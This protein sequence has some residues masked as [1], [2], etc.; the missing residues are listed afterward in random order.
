MAD[1]IESHGVILGRLLN[2]S[3]NSFNKYMSCLRTSGNYKF[4]DEEIAA[5]ELFNC[6]VH[7]YSAL[8]KPLVYKLYSNAIIN[9]PLKWLFMSQL[10]IWLLCQPIITIVMMMTY[11][12][13]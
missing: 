7:T 10:I 3:G 9:T 4:I 13:I 8:P 1:M 2:I 11:E 12:M 6:G 5:V